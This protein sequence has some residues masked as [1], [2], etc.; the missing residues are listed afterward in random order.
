MLHV[1]FCSWNKNLF[2][3]MRLKS[4]VHYS[5]NF[6]KLKKVFLICDIILV[7]SVFSFA[8]FESSLIIFFPLLLNLNETSTFTSF[9]QFPSFID[10]S[11]MSFCFTK[12]VL[13]KGQNNLWLAS[14]ILSA[15]NAV[16]YFYFL[17]L[18]GLLLLWVYM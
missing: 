14:P 7:L 11:H 15:C 16:E 12:T 2:Y 6:V 8:S 9:F 4:L 17:W 3:L 5:S 1:K 13:T 18:L 10:S